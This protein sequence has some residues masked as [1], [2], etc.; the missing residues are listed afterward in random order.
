MLSLSLG[1]LKNSPTSKLIGLM[2]NCLK[3]RC[4]L[5]GINST[6][7]ILSKLNPILLN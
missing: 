7:L 2:N 1:G 4:R 5:W 3:Y 6:F